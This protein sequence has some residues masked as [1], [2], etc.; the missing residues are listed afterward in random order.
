MGKKRAF[1]GRLQCRLFFSYIALIV[2][3]EIGMSSAGFQMG[4]IKCE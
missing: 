4:Q 1:K 3:I 2:Y